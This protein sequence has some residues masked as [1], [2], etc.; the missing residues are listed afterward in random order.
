MGVNVVYA[1]SLRPRHEP[2]NPHLGIRSFGDDPAAVGAARRGDGPGLQS[3]G[4]AATVKH[5]PGL[6]E[7]TS[8]THLGLPD[9]ALARDV[10]DGRELVP[11][12]AA[13]AAGARLGDVRARRAA[14]GDRGRRT[15]RR[16][17]R[18]P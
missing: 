11:F 7:A 14:G 12:R 8:D 17:C 3:A 18:G 6:G 9:L 2:G 10:L 1:P 4:V 15:C 5:F 13:I 16:R